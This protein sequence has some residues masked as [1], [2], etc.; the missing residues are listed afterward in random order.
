MLPCNVVVQEHPDGHVEVAAID[1]VASM[2]AI[3]NPGL[4]ETAGKVR[5][6]LRQVVDDI[7]PAR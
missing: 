1:P 7:E 2:Q 6:M 5:E 4:A 3:D